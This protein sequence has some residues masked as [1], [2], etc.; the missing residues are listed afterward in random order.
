MTSYIGNEITYM[1]PGHLIVSGEPLKISTILG[2]CVSVCLYDP[3]HKISGMNHYLLPMKKDWN[4][5]RFRFGDVSLAYMLGE[6]MNMGSKKRDLFSHV[7]G[8]SSMFGNSS[9]NYNIG[10]KNIDVAFEFLE[11]H[12]IPIKKSDTGGDRG[13][14]VIFDTSAGIISCVFLHG[15]K[16]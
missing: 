9:H 5:N 10:M 2:S 12:N 4:D 13:R 16:K 6:I 8:G 11:F 7:Y 3:R 1:L 14:K 15:Q